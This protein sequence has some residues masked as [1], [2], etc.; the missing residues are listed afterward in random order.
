MDLTRLHCLFFDQPRTL[1]Q[2]ACRCKFCGGTCRHCPSPPVLPPMPLLCKDIFSRS[3]N[4]HAT[5]MHTSLWFCCVWISVQQW[6]YLE[7]RHLSS[8]NYLGS[9]PD[10][11]FLSPEERNGFDLYLTNQQDENTMYAMIMYVYIHSVHLLI[12]GATHNWLKEVYMVFSLK[13][14]CKCWWFV[15]WWWKLDLEQG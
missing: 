2:C 3:C 9:V 15:E 14:S 1:E 4:V 13:N 8:V 5:N 7:A 10:I 6:P 12:W 11:P